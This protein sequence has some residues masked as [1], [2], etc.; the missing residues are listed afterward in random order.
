MSTIA[1]L[2]GVS[3]DFNDATKW[4]GGVVPGA[5]DDAV[6]TAGGTYV[7]TIQDTESNQL[8][9]LTT[10]AGVT[11]EIASGASFAVAGGITN[12]GTI[13]VDDALSLSLAGAIV[14]TGT[15]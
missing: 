11:L 5:G 15:I 7:V 9:S 8:I 4:D 12:A 14:N 13:L 6:I 10:A 1:W 2:S 3:G